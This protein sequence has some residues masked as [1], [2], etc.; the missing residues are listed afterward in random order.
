MSEK[1]VD[2]LDLDTLSILKAKLNKNTDVKEDNMTIKIV[3]E[4]KRSLKFGVV[5]T[6]QAGSRLAEC[7]YK[8]GYNTIVM[9][10]A[11]QDLE[12]I[13]LPED[14]K[15]LFK[16]GLGGAAK[17]LEIGKEAA[18]SHRNHINLMVHDKLSGSDVF[19]VCVSL[20]GG[21]GA[22]SVGT[23]I[24]VLSN[25][26]SPIVVISVLPME[27][28]DAQTKHNSLQTLSQLA[29]LVQE[30][31][32][33]SMVVVD[34]AKIEAIFSDVSQL[35]F[36]DVANQAIVEPINT[37]NELS[38]QPSPYKALDSTEWAKLLIDGEGLMVFG[39]LTVSNY[40]EETAIAE[41]VINNLDSNLLAGGFDLKQSKY[42]GFIVAANE[43][44]LE[45]LPAKNINYAAA[46][47]QEQAG[48]PKSM[49]RGVYVTSD[50]ED[51]VRVYSCFAGLS[52]PMSRVDS[53]KK[54][55]LELT[56]QAKSKDEVRNLSLTLDTGTDKVVSAAQKVR[57]QVAAKNSAFGKLMGNVINK[58]K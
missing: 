8:Q 38:A 22:G 44:V 42:V 14:N 55:A 58:R 34:N 32:V 29:K 1:I 6:G 7:F 26:G 56:A 40:Q 28:D 39:S 33:Q 5:G 18:E 13:N 54:E 30:K 15:L 45:K 21:S 2:D 51:H 31:K 23:I 35:K 27:N 25:V 47:V 3:E 12:H 50:T 37:F 46:I 16:Y 11:P 49:F 36:F 52:L 57:E 48:T 41:A 20:G 9:N 43:K 24:D 19:I 17:E 4:K 53:L 10:T